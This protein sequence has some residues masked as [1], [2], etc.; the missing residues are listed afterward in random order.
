MQET[1]VN[2]SLCKISFLIEIFFYQDEHYLYTSITLNFLSEGVRFQFLP[3]SFPF[4]R[5]RYCFFAPQ[6]CWTA[7]F[8]ILTTRI[9]QS[10]KYFIPY[11]RFTNVACKWTSLNKWIINSY[12]SSFDKRVSECGF[13]QTNLSSTAKLTIPLKSLTIHHTWSYPYFI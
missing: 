7:L 5:K 13:R 2:L 9:S 12:R 8:Q 4:D 1:N 6:E 11:D 10:Y 3:R